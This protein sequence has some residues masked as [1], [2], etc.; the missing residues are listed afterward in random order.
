MPDLIGHLILVGSD[1][2]VSG[3]FDVLV[4][5]E[6]ANAAGMNMTGAGILNRDDVALDSSLY[7]RVLQG[8][9][10]IGAKGTVLK[11]K[12]LCVAERLAAGNM[13]ANQLKVAGMPAQELSV[14]N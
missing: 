10:G 9:I 13:A 4:K 8:K 5:N 11:D 3:G 1:D 14:N 2:A 7:G 12:I 6:L